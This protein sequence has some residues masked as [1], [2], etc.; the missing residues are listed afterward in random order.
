MT[1]KNINRLLKDKY[2]LPIE[3]QRGGGDRD[4]QDTQQQ[5]LNLLENLRF[6][7]GRS[8]KEIFEAEKARKAAEEEEKRLKEIA[9]QQEANQ[10]NSS[11][12]SDLQDDAISSHDSF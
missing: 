11:T 1:K 2:S 12:D 10:E 4:M 5:I 8:L 3:L 9:E 6:K 7:D